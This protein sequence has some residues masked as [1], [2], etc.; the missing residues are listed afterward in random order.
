MIL[1]VWDIGDGSAS[2]VTDDG[3][4]ALRNAEAGM[5]AAG[6]A[7]ATVEQAVH[8]GGGSWMRSGYERTGQ[9]WR[10]Q[11]HGERITWAQFSGPAGRAAT[12]TARRLRTSILSAI[13]HRGRRSRSRRSAGGRV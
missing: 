1:W 12:L 6:A 4:T 10:A 9:G 7:T 13:S 8:L 11:R 2:G 5:S 3:S